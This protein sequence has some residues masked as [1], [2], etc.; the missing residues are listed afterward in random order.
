MPAVSRRAF[1]LLALLSIPLA[2]GKFEKLSP[3]QQVEYRV[4]SAFMTDEQRKAW[5]KMKTDE[6]RTA[7]L[8]EHDLYQKFYD[9]PPERRDEIVAGK[10]AVGWT[11]D[12]TYLAWGQPFQKQ[13]LTGREAARS[14]LLVYR[15]EVDKDG[16]ATPAVGDKED[17]QAVRRYQMELVVD[18][19]VVAESVR[20]ETWE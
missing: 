15:F 2:A 8:K 19:D 10:V 3:D 18:D 5:L 6:E 4:F 20:K 14:E 13:R 12:Q 9:A 16:F 1:A 17:Y 11:R 7:W